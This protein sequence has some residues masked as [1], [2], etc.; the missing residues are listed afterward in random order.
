[1]SGYLQPKLDAQF[2]TW[3]VKY[4]VIATSMPSITLVTMSSGYFQGEDLMS[5][6]YASVV[7][8]LIRVHLL[9][10]K[11]ILNSL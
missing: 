11:H 10:F 6:G 3:Q 5:D 9:W 2:S 7:Q 8:L 4:S 1:M